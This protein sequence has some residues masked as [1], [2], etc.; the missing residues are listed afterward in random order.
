MERPLPGAANQEDYF[1]FD[2]LDV[3]RSL[4]GRIL[5]APHVHYGLFVMMPPGVPVVPVT[6][7]GGPSEPQ[8]VS[9]WLLRDADINRRLVDADDVQLRLPR[10]RD[11]REPRCSLAALD[12]ER[13]RGDREQI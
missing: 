1:R 7:V 8:P 12:R 5:M 2:S 3:E 11:S 10:G 6:T 13:C 9:E 4:S